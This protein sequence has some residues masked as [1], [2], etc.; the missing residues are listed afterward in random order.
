MWWPSLA[1]FNAARCLVKC[2]ATWPWHTTVLLL[3]MPGTSYNWELSTRFCQ[4]H[5]WFSDTCSHIRLFDF[6]VLNRQAKSWTEYC[7]LQRL[8]SRV[9]KCMLESNCTSVLP[10]GVLAGARRLY[11]SVLVDK[12]PLCVSIQIAILLS[13]SRRGHD[14]TL[15]FGLHQYFKQ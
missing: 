8:S 9:G 3:C 12:W 14:K 4:E 15:P 11:F 13:L 6:V 5:A 10:Y 1:P 7:C 2:R